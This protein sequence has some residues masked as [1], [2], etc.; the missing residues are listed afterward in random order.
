MHKVIFLIK[1]LIIY[2]FFISNGFTTKSNYFDQGKTLFKNND[3]EKSKF[4]FEK[5]IVFNPKSEKSYLYLAKI[6]KENKND[7]QLEM[8]LN[9]VLLI[10]PN[11]DESLYMLTVL[12][13]KQSDYNHA[14]E[15]IN[16]FNLVCKS[17]CSKK[18]EVEEKFNKLTPDD[19]KD[20]N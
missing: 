18:T 3:F 12:K 16:T 8:N 11:N 1:I 6:Y 9:N 10:N 7:E 4:F 13:I 15:L 20:N 17:F 14:K 2:S 5:D 19:A